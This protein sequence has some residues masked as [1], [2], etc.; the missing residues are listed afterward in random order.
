[1][2]FLLE[3]RTLAELVLCPACRRA[4]AQGIRGKAVDFFEISFDTP[5]V[6]EHN[7]EVREFPAYV[8]QTFGNR[9][10][11]LRPCQLIV[12]WRFGSRPSSNDG[13]AGLVWRMMDK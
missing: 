6:I 9:R 12:Y 3:C 1:M 5:A 7:L 13:G 2:L 4:S 11:F 8:S 10:P